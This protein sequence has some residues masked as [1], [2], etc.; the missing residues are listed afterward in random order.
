FTGQGYTIN[1]T[2]Q[3][4]Q[5]WFGESGADRF[6]IKVTPQAS[7]QAVSVEIEDR[8]QARRFISV[9]TTAAL[10]ADINGLM[11]QSFQLF[12]VLNLIGVVIGALGVTN[13]L[14]MNVME[15]QREIGGLRSL[16]MTR[17]QV[18]RM[19]L[20]EAL[21]LGSMGA[22][23]GLVFGYVMA[24]ILVWAMNLMNGYELV[25]VFT[26]QPF[27]LGVLIAFGVAQ[28]AA[29]LPARRAARVNIVEAIKHE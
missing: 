27:V 16:G 13:T 5:R 9:Q 4:L 6:T 7:V 21:A 24:Q 22:I 28:G 29:L 15:R 12:D 25:Y 2:Y 3:D 17:H 8:Y 20:A 26:A 18:L 10:K 11:D 19:I 23:Y 1:G 14:T